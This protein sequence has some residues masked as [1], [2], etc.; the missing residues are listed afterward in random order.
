MPTVTCHS[1]ASWED[2]E[3]GREDVPG[4]RMR[5]SQC[6]LWARRG[7]VERALGRMIQRITLLWIIGVNEADRRE[8][9]KEGIVVVGVRERRWSVQ[10]GIVA[11]SE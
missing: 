2:I 5:R 3:V 11:V 4:R 10:S 9:M 6:V 1:A 7:T 8:E